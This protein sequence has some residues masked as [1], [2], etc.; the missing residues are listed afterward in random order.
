M[1]K[2]FNFIISIFSIFFLISIC[3]N[4]NTLSVSYDESRTF[5]SISQN[6]SISNCL[7]N[8]IVTLDGETISVTPNMIS[9]NTSKLGEQIV[10]VTYAGQTATTSAIICTPSKYFTINSTEPKII[11]KYT[12]SAPTVI[13]PKYIN[14]HEITTLGTSAFAENKTLTSI[15]ANNITAIN[16]NAFFWCNLTFV[17]F[18]KATSIGDRA[19]YTCPL[20]SINFPNVASIGK[21]A[22]DSCENLVS[23]DFPKV[24]SIDDETFSYCD[25]LTNIS[26]PNVTSIGDEA[27]YSCINL[28]SVDFPKVD[29]IGLEAF[30][31]CDSLTNISFPNATYIDLGA[32][33]YCISLISANFPKVTTIEGSA[34]YYCKLLT[35]VFFPLANSIGDIAFGDCFNLTNVTLGQV[36][37]AF[38][39]KVFSLNYLVPSPKNLII[40]VPKGTYDKYRNLF[41]KNEN[42]FYLRDSFAIVEY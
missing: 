12:G 29:S 31:C 14:Y 10:T 41:K 6:D 26:F 36:P 20:V 2:H 9:L 40:K 38:D 4:A 7:D 28:V 18:P 22:F 23:V 34:F 30:S 16:D 39:D 19:F 15:I 3:S 8:F 24:N 1:N 17:D 11:S 35:N 21:E 27:F 42:T 25:S 33:S 5:K 32:F 13:V 37:T